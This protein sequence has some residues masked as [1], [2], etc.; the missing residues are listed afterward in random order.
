LWAVR[1][2][3]LLLFG[4]IAARLGYL[5][6]YC[7]A[8]LS[9]RAIREHSADRTEGPPRGAVLDRAGRV[10]AMTIEGGSCF[11]DPRRVGD[12][13]QTA[14]ALSPLVH[15]SPAVLQEKLRG[16]RRFVWLAR[17]LDPETTQKL[18][19]LHAPGIY[20][21][22]ERKRFYPDE[23]LAAHVLGVV[24]TDHHGL[25]GVEQVADGWLSGRS[26]PFLFRQWIFQGEPVRLASQADPVPCSVVLTLDR[27]LQYIA[28]QELAA[29]M[30][31]SGARNGTVIIEDPQTGDI[32]A[33]ASAPTFDPNLWG[34]SGA[35]E[36][37][38]P[39]TLKNPAVEKVME[40]GSTFK[41]VAAAAALDQEVVHPDDAFFC[42]NGS[43]EIQGRTIHDH[44]KDGWLS[45]SEVIS[46]SS[47]IGTAKVALKLGPERLYRY[48]RAFGF[49]MPTGCGLPG[50][51]TGILRTPDQWHGAALETIAF[52]Q[53][54]GVTPLQLVNAYA[55]VANGGML[56]EPRL[57]KGI[58]DLHGTYHEWESFPPVR[59]VISQRT[60]ALLRKILLSVV[61]SGTGKA[62]RV[63]GIAVAGKT[64]TAQK[65][66][67][68]THQYSPD[69]Y[70]ASFCGFVP[71]DHPRLVIGVF[72][73][74]PKS[75]YWGGSEAA[76]LFARIVRDTAPY[77]H[78]EAAPL[79]PLAV[80]HIVLK[81]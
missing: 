8:M 13:V 21:I 76:P 77:L 9:E 12:V 57:Y 54:V 30:A 38:G 50:D 3:S 66:D 49:G 61:E 35:P 67:P 68:R 81:S 34:T 7:H 28:E 19:E 24:G 6:I 29:Q 63:P 75:S 36:D 4:A 53:E 60:V 40:P 26:V 73:D 58:L 52:G 37:Y 17:R 32:L 23:T 20:V 31:V 80:S 45:F 5:Q 71:V 72:L 44:E 64:G 11:A 51:G 14:Q 62:A 1:T 18:Q 74:E 79:G 59:R 16:P 65:I 22:P 43:W 2:V 48:A 27:E 46:H 69:L 39:D 56:L 41:L 70:L 42:E 55:A 33:M 78:L 47:N 25:S 15:V 10:L